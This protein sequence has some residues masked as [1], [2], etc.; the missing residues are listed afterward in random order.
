MITNSSR[1]FGLVVGNPDDVI[2]DPDKML[3]SYVKNL[4]KTIK[5]ACYGN[6]VEKAMAA[7]IQDLLD[8]QFTAEYVKV[9]IQD[10]DEKQIYNYKN[11]PTFWSY[12]GSY[13]KN[14]SQIFET[15]N[16]YFP[17]A[18]ICAYAKCGE[19][20]IM[21][22]PIFSVEGKDDDV[23]LVEEDIQMGFDEMDDLW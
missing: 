2:G 12:S 16:L 15:F 18:P 14:I 7:Y 13:L 19:H 21:L 1:A 17:T 4:N 10:I 11:N 5:D 22:S 6:P 9:K 8:N 20:V 3:K 23:I